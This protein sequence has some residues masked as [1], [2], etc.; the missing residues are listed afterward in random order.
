MLVS[1]SVMLTDVNTC[2][3]EACGEKADLWTPLHW[4]ATIGDTRLVSFLLDK[5]AETSTI[6]TGQS[7][8]IF[9]GVTPLIVGFKVT[10]EC[11]EDECRRKY[12][13][14]AFYRLLETATPEMI[15]V[16][17]TNAADIWLTDDS[18]CRVTN[19]NSRFSEDEFVTEAPL[20]TACD[21]LD[22]H[23]VNALLH[24]AGIAHIASSSHRPAEDPD[25]HV[26]RSSAFQLAARGDCCEG[27]IRKQ[28]RDECECG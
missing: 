12:E 7:A 2:Y 28:R 8:F 6:A 25:P 24:N 9:A 16:R 4:A 13:T 26:H 23:L 5:G 11:H 20:A 15:I 14:A 18:R 10:Y 19:P 1:A 17:L 21:M 27:G 3:H 22:L